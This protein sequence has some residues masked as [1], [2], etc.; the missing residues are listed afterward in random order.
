ML[1]VDGA[2]NGHFRPMTAITE[3]EHT[4][5][6]WIFT[7]KDTAVAR[8]VKD[9]RRRAMA[10]YSAKGH[11][12]FATVHG[13]IE[14]DQNRA[15]I[16][17]LWNPFIAAWFDGKNDPKLALLRFEAEHGEIWLNENSVLAGV[18]MLFGADPTQE[19]EDKVAK[20]RLGGSR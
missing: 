2:E 19:Y 15:M 11:R 7:A 10:A 12:L 8:A 20:V 4:G 9:I 14:L 16:E 18:R 1:G 13:T 5:P 17:K 6:V 3:H